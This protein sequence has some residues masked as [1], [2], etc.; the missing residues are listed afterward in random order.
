MACRW[1]PERGYYAMSQPPFGLEVTGDRE[2]DVQHGA[3]RILAIMEHWIAETPE[4]WLMYHPVWP[5]ADD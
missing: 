2:A 5:E 1:A 4:Q 3:R